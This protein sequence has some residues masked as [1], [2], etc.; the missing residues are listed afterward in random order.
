MHEVD[1][2]KCLLL[3]LQEWKREHEPHTPCVSAV[4]LEVGDFTCV[5]PAALRF[6]F[7]AAVQGS[8][9]DGSTLEIATVPLRA[10]CL[11]CSAVYVPEPDQ[12]YRSPCCERPMEEIISGRELRI[13]SVDY[14]LSPQP[15]SPR[16]SGSTSL[17]SR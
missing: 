2:T 14:S 11:G 10:R 8:W 3:S 15:S 12:A 9:L 1:M 17:S 16:S 6:T 13:C 7:A 4:H 5:E